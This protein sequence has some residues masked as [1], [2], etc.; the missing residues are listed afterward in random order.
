MNTTDTICAIASGIGGAVA[1]IRISGAK[2]LEVANQVWRGKEPLSG[3][4]AREMR[5]GKILAI[6]DTALAVY[7]PNPKSYTGDDVVELQC[8]GGAFAARRVL[9]AVIS[10]GARLAEAGEFTFRAFVNGK[11]DL[12][13][14]EAVG[15]IVNAGSSMALELAERQLSGSLSRKIIQLRTTLIDTLGDLE[16]RLD[17]PEEHI[18][19]ESP[20]ELN[21]KIIDVIMSLTELSNTLEAGQIYRQ[22]VGVVLAGQPNVGKSSLLNALLGRDRAI[23]SDIAGTTR[24]TLEEH[25]TLRGIPVRITD[26]AGI[27]DNAELIEQLG[28]ER[29]KQQLRSGSIIFWLMDGSAT[30]LNGEVEQAKNEL[31]DIAGK[32]IAIWNK[33]D[34]VD[35]AQL[36]DSGF[37]Q[38]CI[39]VKEDYNINTLLDRFEELV[40]QD[41][42]PD[43]T[44]EVAVNE[45][46]RIALNDAVAAL[47]SAMPEI[48]SEFWELGAVHLR[49]AVNELGSITGETAEVD[50]LDNIFS[51]F[52]IGK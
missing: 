25:A 16:S 49:I 6:G 50:I 20:A 30:D 15:D 10:A 4:T 33:C 26:T 28:I 9:E 12:A 39:S 18:D 31:K 11:L 23:V 8:H 52:C 1:I 19:W 38:I 3:S 41:G 47:A 21:Q 17:F 43:A 48:E 5:L 44:P 14:A 13:Q 51:R 32:V 42:R 35:E 7:M 24:D 40:W 45:R 46:H 36:P 37:N 29:S 27:R 22:G 34:L 2:A